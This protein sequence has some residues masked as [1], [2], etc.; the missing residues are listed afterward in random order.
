LE[1]AERIR[2]LTQFDLEYKQY[3]EIGYGLALAY[4]NY[5]EQ[6]MQGI[7]MMEEYLEKFGITSPDCIYS[8]LNA[9]GHV[10]LYDRGIEIANLAIEGIRKYHRSNIIVPEVSL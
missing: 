5:V 6:Q 7:A 9:F 10:G 8:I 4:S 3:G 1:E 2:K